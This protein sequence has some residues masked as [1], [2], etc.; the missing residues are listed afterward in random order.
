MQLPTQLSVRAEI[1]A[2]LQLAIPLASAQ[3][4]QAATGFVD[5]LMMGWLGQATLAA[6]GLA[7]TTYT[8]VLVIASGVLVSVSP[9]VATAAGAGERS[10]IQQL[11]Q[12]GL[13]LALLIGC[14]LTLLMGNIDHLMRQL[15]QA[16]PLTTMAHS[17]LVIMR[18]GLLPALLFAIL[19]G[20]MSALSQTRP[21][22]LIVILGTLL[23]AIGNYAIGLG[24][25]GLPPLGLVGIAGAS[26]ISQWVMVL[27]LGLY[28]LW[29]AQLRQYRC[30][31]QWQPL[32][33]KILRELLELG[34][35]IALAF[36]LEIGLFT[37][38]TY[39]MGNL[40]SDV[41]AA[42]QIVFQTIAIIF[43]VPLGMSMATTIRVGQ[44]QGQQNAIAIQKTSY[45]S[46]GLSGLFMGSM[47][48]LLLFFP[49]LIIGLYLDLN[50]PNNAKVIQL[51]TAMMTVAAVS[52]VLDGVQTTAAG[53]LRGLKDT[54]IPL[55]ISFLS[56]WG[57]GLTSG[58]VLGFI[59]NLGGVGLWLGQ[60][61]GVAAA[62]GL[63]M[64]RL[65]QLLTRSG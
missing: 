31:Q 25:W 29:S 63:F 64:G 57:V 1:R 60:L 7:A 49:N 3:V 39:L 13:W 37:T 41:L 20:V 16:E 28:W 19:K 65:Q 6:G 55:L 23:N 50:D 4:A 45:I 2:S 40:G 27:G 17:Y 32:N 51:T 5:T 35:P 54:K 56:F 21:I 9:L 42:H 61:L 46:M 18:W 36:G 34:V 26:V 10:R 15:G 24:H 22:T 12:Q 14:P 47:A 62:A 58:Y 43:M 48:L 59:L 53:A 30:F 44:W 38:T 8:M 33:P 52:Q 11:T